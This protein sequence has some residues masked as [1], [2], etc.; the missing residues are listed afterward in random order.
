MAVTCDLCGRVAAGEE[1]P[2]TW[3]LSMERGRVQRYCEECTRENL[4]AM[5]GKLATEHW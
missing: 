5:E 2:L 1:P 3:S 4:R